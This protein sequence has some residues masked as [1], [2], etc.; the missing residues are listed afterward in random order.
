[1]PPPSERRGRLFRELAIALAAWLAAAVTLA[2]PA[3]ADAFDEGMDAYRRGEY[4]TALTLLRPLAERGDPPAQ[5]YLGL[6]YQDGK[7]LPEDLA[8][9]LGWYRRAA[10]RNLPSAQKNLADLYYLGKGVARDYAA[11]ANWYRKAAEAG[12][13]EAQFMIGHMYHK[14]YGVPQDRAEAAKWYRTAEDQ[15]YVISTVLDGLE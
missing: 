11:A 13:S 15:G 7:G 12:H 2:E 14:G 5:Y 6:M 3:A 9:A 10:D 1:M 8:Q 4:A